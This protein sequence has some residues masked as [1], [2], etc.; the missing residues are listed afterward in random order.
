MDAI[1]P[2]YHRANIKPKSSHPHC[3]G[4]KSAK[5]LKLSLQNS[6]R[7]IAAL[8]VRGDTLAGRSELVQ[9]LLKSGLF[10]RQFASQF[11]GYLLMEFPQFIVKS[12]FSLKADMDFPR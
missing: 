8:V 4:F 6:I 11:R 9:P 1:S 7:R 2:T 12:L 5:Q 3:G 10:A